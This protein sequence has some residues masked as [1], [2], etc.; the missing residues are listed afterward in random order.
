MKEH[1]YLDFTD[2]T[3]TAKI[4]KALSSDVRLHILDIIKYKPLNIS[5][6]AERAEIPI[7][8]AALH[9]KTLEDAGIVITQS[10]PGL[11][12]FQRVCGLR[13]EKVEFTL[14]NQEDL[15]KNKNIIT[16]SIPIGNY[17]DCDITAPCG[18]VS[19]TAFLAA[20]D[21]LYGF[22]SPNKHTAQIIWFTKG[23][24]E[25]RFSTCQ[26]KKLKRV[27]SI[28][29]SFEICSEAPGYNNNWKSDIS[30]WI[31]GTDIGYFTTE[32]DYGGRR[33]KLNPDWWNDNMTQYGIL[34]SIRLS[35]S[36]TFM[37]EEKVSPFTLSDY[38]LTD[39]SYISFKIGVKEDARYVGG[40]NLFGEKFGDHPQN[41][42]MRIS[43]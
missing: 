38:N 17:F 1:L 7:S 34:K 13:V 5:E 15:L 20:E 27:S 12:G 37:D 23:Y 14:L 39:K 28:E 33:G 2:M 31:N 24:L 36:G 40:M 41:I 30:V 32:A 35:H 26:L 10:M 18:I 42:Q 3:L 16:E 19:D 43:F 29:F 11:R 8:S 4:A 22:Y 21:S 6:I 25:Y 9:I